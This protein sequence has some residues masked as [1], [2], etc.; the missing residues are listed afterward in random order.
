MKKLYTLLFA[1]LITSTA[2]S[3]VF[4]TELADPNNNLN[5]RYIELYNAGPTPVDFTEGSGWQIDKYLNAS[6][7][8]TTSLDLTGTIPAGGFYLIAYD[9]SAGTFLSVYGFAPDQLDPVS[10]GVAGSNGDD[11]IFLVD[12]TDAIVDAF[13]TPGVDNTGT[14][15]EYEDGRAERKASV[16]SGVSTWNEAEWNVWAD[17]TVN[18]CTSHLNDPRTAP[19]DYDPGAWDGTVT[20]PTITLGA[21]VTGLDYFEGSGPSSEG[22]FSVDGINLSEGILVTA[23]TN[24]EVSLTSG[25][26]FTPTVTVTQ[27][28]GTASD[29]VYVR[30]VSGLSANTYTDNATATSAGASSQ[31][32]SLSGT[33]TPTDPQITISGTPLESLDYVVSNGPSQVDSFNVEGLFLT[34]DI[35]VTSPSPAFE[36]SLLLAGP[37]TSS[38]NVSFGAGTVT[39]TPIFVR[40]AA[41]L[42]EGSYSEDL[43]VSTTGVTNELVAATGTVFGPPT[44]SLTITG[45]FDALDGSVVKGVE[46]Y[47]NQDIPDLSV[48]GI[49]SANNGG[50]SN[51]IEFAFPAVPV[52]AGDFLYVGSNLAF[53]T[54]FAPIATLDYVTAAMLIN[55]DDAIELYENLVLI[56]LFG[57][58][59]LDGTGQS[60]EYLDGW[61]YR[62]TVGPNVTFTDTEWDYSGVGNLDGATNSVSTNPFPIQDYLNILSVDDIA[63]KRFKIYPNPTNTGFVNITSLYSEMINAK[64]F[65]ILGKEVL[66]GKVEN[67][68]LNLSVLSPGMYILKLSQNKAIITKKLIIQ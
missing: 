26:T 16:T 13:G 60:W 24:F 14:C 5:A 28:S 66:S 53:D 56:D 40:L 12:G 25:G 4:I 37:Y 20:D 33:V 29:V 27:T 58:P 46:L 39:T 7:T 30:L 42:P 45:V 61:A 15:A 21:D 57:D 17:S 22:S 59:N 18:G 35:V 34:S 31:T 11:D 3:Q 23:P 48:Y 43:T 38:V 51:G 68:Q 8:V 32:V 6:A 67:H 9:N 2:F 64:V 41:G 10:N 19:G 50:G 63:D 65:D 1:I 44:N 54:F 52:T 62:N 36:L 47:C 49:G 55:G